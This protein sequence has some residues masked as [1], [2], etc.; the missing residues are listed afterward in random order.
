MYVVIDV[1]TTGLF[2]KDRIVEIAVAQLDEHGRV[3]A[4]W[5]TLV[6]P[7]RDLGP[8]ELH[9]VRAADVRRA[10]TFDQIAGDVIELLRDRVPVAHNLAFDSRLLAH[11]YLRLGCEIPNLGRFGVCTMQW[12]DHFLP[13]AGRSLA[14]C[15]LAGG[16]ANER[17]H[18]AMSD[19]LATAELLALYLNSMGPAPLWEDRGLDPDAPV[20]PSIPAW[21]TEP[22]RRGAGAADGG[23]FLTRLVDHIPR[24]PDPPQADTYLALLDRALVDRH[25][26]ATEADLLVTLAADLGIGRAAAIE[27]HRG[28][29]RSLAAAALSDGVVSASERD[30]LNR[31]AG[32]LSLSLG[33]VDEALAAGANGP[34]PVRARPEYR[35]KGGDV[36]VLTGAFAESKSFWAKRLESAGLSVSPNVTKKTSLVVAADPDSLSGKAVKARQYG[37]PVIGVDSLDTVLARMAPTSR[38]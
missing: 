12:A 31:V 19:V 29:L 37:I 35:L 32:L 27:L 34:A 38:V 10:P 30:D 15:C 1:E 4:A 6:N 13:D 23:A 17:P 33:A 8:Q 9:G 18:E 21:S 7:R 11:E 28:Y 16:I 24:V 36:A 3:T 26:S 5:E 14:D 2:N 22:V 20:W 25:I